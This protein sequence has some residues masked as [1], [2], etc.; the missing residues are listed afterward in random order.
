MENVKRTIKLMLVL[1]LFIVSCNNSSNEQTRL[2][3]KETELE[4]KRKELELKE[5]ELELL[6]KKNQKDF[7]LPNNLNSISERAAIK[8]SVSPQ[9]I[10]RN[11]G[12]ITF[13]SKDRVMFFYDKS[14]NRGKIVINNIECFVNKY[15]EKNNE[16]KGDRISIKWLNL[17]YKDNEGGDCFY[18]TCDLDVM[19]DNSRIKLINLDFQDCPLY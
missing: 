16:F 14:E 4:L 12:Q 8:I 10:G 5:R 15:D 1:C 2:K 11:L 18:G 3:L 19:K 17:N 7:V 9:D 13:S 6:E